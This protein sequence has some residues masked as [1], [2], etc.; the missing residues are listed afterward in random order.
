MTQNDEQDG[1]LTL[2]R[3]GRLE[4]KKTVETGQVRQSFS[5]GRTKSVTV[6]VRKKRTFERGASGRMR[7]VQDTDALQGEISGLPEDS[8]NLTEQERA[9]RVRAL[10]DAAADEER[11]RIDEVE[12]ERQELAEAEAQ[13]LRDE[14]EAKRRVEEESRRKS[15]EDTRRKTDE[16]VRR[17]QPEPVVPPAAPEAKESSPAAAIPAS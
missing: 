9:A 6:E 17:R 4:L 7:V 14:A 2:S 13:R 5:H 11:R 8:D 3:P 1:K 15:E 10:H 12:R 16:D